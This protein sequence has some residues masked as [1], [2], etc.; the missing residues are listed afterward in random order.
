VATGPRNIAVLMTTSRNQLLCSAF[1]HSNL[2]P[3]FQVTPCCSRI[4]ALLGNPTSIARIL[5]AHGSMQDSLIGLWR[6][7]Q[8]RTPISAQLNNGLESTDGMMLALH[9]A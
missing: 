3:F 7:E 4:L 8:A 1:S 5:A 6:L 9:H 2:G